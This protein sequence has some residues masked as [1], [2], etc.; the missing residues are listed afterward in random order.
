[1]VHRFVRLSV[2][3]HASLLIVAC[4][5][6][7]DLAAADTA[8]AHFH[9]QLD[10]QDYAAIY[11]Q[12]DQKL[13][14]AAKQDDFVALMT[15]IH[16]KL[17]QAGSATRQSFF[18]NYNTSGTQIR[19]SY[20]TKFGEGDAQEQFA[21]AKNGNNLTLLTYNINSNALITK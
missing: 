15:A 9:K 19:V 16:R 7:K 12:A 14:D 4:G 11:A 3:L 5:T 1:M 21:W 8:V 20:S 6:Q 18:V 17:G 2:C 13:R 10:M